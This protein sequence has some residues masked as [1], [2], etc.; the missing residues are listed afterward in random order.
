LWTQADRRSV[1]R[2][3]LGGGGLG[4][5]LLS[6]T[7]TQTVLYSP[8]TYKMFLDKQAR[9]LIDFGTTVPSHLT[10]AWMSTD[11]FIKD[12]PQAVQKTLP[13]RVR[14]RRL[15]QNPKN[16]AEAVKLIADDRRDPANIAEAELDSNILSCRG[17]GEMRRT[18]SARALDMGQA[19]RHDGS[20]AG[21][22]IYVTSFKTVP[23]AV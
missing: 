12:K 17:N 1:H 15:L 3:P 20:G 6:A 8:L 9:S 13:M 21:R 16:R 18:G 19:D 7:S 11:Q 14:R 5:N 22:D 10:G 4:T 23:T 2:V